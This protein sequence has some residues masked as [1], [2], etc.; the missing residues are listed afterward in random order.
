MTLRHK[1]ACA[2]CASVRVHSVSHQRVSLKRE[3]ERE[4]GETQHALRCNLNTNNTHT[5]RHRHRTPATMQMSTPSQFNPPTDSQSPSLS[6]PTVSQLQQ[7]SKARRAQH[8]KA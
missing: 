6:T 7:H 1:Q 5:H 2:A 3:N 8:I 4:P